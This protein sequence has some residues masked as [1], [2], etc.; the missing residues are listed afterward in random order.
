MGRACDLLLPNNIQ[1]RKQL[2]ILLHKIVIF[3]LSEILWLPLKEQ[4]AIIGAALQRG[5]CGR[6]LRCPLTDSQQ[7]IGAH[8]LAVCKKLNAANR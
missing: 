6:D 1:D 2:E 4:A 8:K 7:E 3:I 5:P